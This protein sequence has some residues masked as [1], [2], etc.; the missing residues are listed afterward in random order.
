MRE[1]L[2]KDSK[3]ESDEETRIVMSGKEIKTLTDLRENFNFS[4]AIEIQK[5]GALSKWLK[6]LYYESEAEN[7]HPI[8]F[9]TWNSSEKKRFCNILGVDYASSLLDDEKAVFDSNRAKLA[10]LT[11]DINVLNNADVVAAD[12]CQLATLINNGE[13]T[14]V[15]YN[16]EFSIP[17]SKLKIT[18]YCVGSPKITNLCTAE[19]YKK[20]GIVMNG[21][22]LPTEENKNNISS[23]RA[24][25]R[26]NGYDFFYE[27]HSGLANY[28][29]RRFHQAIDVPFI[30]NVGTIDSIPV[31]RTKSECERAKNAEIKRF[32]KKAE[33]YLSPSTEH[34]FV[35]EYE[36]YYSRLITDAFNDVKEGLNVI[37]ERN[38]KK[39]Q[40]DKLKE[41]CENASQNLRKLFKDEITDGDYYKM[42]DLNYFLGRVDVVKHDYGEGWDPASRFLMHFAEGWIEYHYE[43]L[44][45]VVNELQEDIDKFSATFSKSAY[46]MYKDYVSKIEDLAEDIGKDIQIPAGKSVEEYLNS[47]VSA[48][49][50]GENSGAYS[51]LENLFK[52]RIAEQSVCSGSSAMFRI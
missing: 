9:S 38:G 29:H 40:Y 12:Q 41:F 51:N 47:T 35:R 37:C 52:P 50:G 21:I 8:R 2:N 23:F 26:N 3:K 31:F 27:E 33:S 20:L 7:V 10:E 32:Y 28:F 39:K 22:E 24:A 18:Y 11:D 34:G 14:I 44:G 25:A 48:M 43:W 17:M 49:T 4:E 19:Q 16:G 5:S 1:L 42:Y 30:F 46:S 36:E 6:E 13:K 45:D 15:L